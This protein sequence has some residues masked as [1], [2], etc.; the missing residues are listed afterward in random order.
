MQASFGCCFAKELNKQRL[1]P[2]TGDGFDPSHYGG[3]ACA[4]KLIRNPK[5]EKGEGG[6]GE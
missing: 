2:G 3:G 1:D 4:D 6:E 5:M